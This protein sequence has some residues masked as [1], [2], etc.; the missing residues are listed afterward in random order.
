MIAS[1]GPDTS[2]T[3]RQYGFAVDL[4]PEHAKMGQLVVAAA[5]AGELLIR[6][7]HAIAVYRL[8][9]HCAGTGRQSG[10]DATARRRVAPRGQRE[11]WDDGPFMKACRLEPTDRTPIW[12]MRQAGRYMPEYRA[13]REKTTFLE[14][15]KN[16]AL[17]AEVMITAVRR[18]GVDAAIIFAD[19]LPILEPMGMELEFTHGEGPVIHNPVRE[20]RDV[21]RVLELDDVEP[22]QFRDGDGSADAGRLAAG[23]SAARV[24]R[25]AVHAGQLRDR[26]GREPQVICT[27]RR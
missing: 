13:V 15:C 5:R 8:A 27:P 17:C 22:L 25:C 1:I 23:D 7:R 12:L 26:R 6:K 14:L 3:L 16:P 24:R 9:S 11:P 19:L 10:R 4:E 20:P 2:E 21:D 18:L